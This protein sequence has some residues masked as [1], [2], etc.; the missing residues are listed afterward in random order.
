M[1]ARIACE[2]VGT[3]ARKVLSASQKLALHELQGGICPLCDRPMLPGDKLTDEHLRALGLGGSNRFDN[4]AMTHTPCA[5]AKTYGP[6]G[7]LAKIAQAKARKR[8]NLGF[9]APKR[10]IQSPGF[11]QTEPQARATRSLVKALPPRRS[12]FVSNTERSQ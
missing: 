11:A 9:T 8:K 3:T 12:L 10:P 4:R 2:D 1:T 5:Q 7:D 6:D